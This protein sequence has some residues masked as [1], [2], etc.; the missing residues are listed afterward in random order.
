MARR[1]TRSRQQRNK[2]NYDARYATHKWRPFNI[3]DQVK[4]RKHDHPIHR[5][6]G[7]SKFK[8][9]WKGPYT[10]V[11]RKGVNVKVDNGMMKRWM[12]TDLVRP[13]HTREQQL[14]G[15]AG[16]EARRTSTT[17]NS[18]KRQEQERVSD[19]GTGISQHNAGPT[20]RVEKGPRATTGRKSA[21]GRSQ[22][23][24]EERPRIQTKTPIVMPQGMTPSRVTPG[25]S[26]KSRAFE[27]IQ[28]GRKA[29]YR[30]GDTKQNRRS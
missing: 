10:V 21:P 20:G 12:N 25:R 15:G 27:Q 11:D 19:R 6:P 22:T 24:L 16:V 29:T 17:R 23:I 26:S 4:V 13:W 2:L 8:E 28:A 9:R 7:A 5:G 30:S 18:R 1:G 3:G 14:R